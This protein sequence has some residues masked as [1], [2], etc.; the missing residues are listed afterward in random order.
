MRSKI[1]LLIILAALASMIGCGGTKFVE[2]GEEPTSGATFGPAALIRTADHLSA[3]LAKRFQH[4][5]ERVPIRVDIVKNKTSEHIDTKAVTDTI[6]TNLINSGNFKFSVDYT[7]LDQ[8]EK[9]VMKEIH[10]RI[11][12]MDRQMYLQNQVAPK[13]RVY[14]ELT[15]IKN[16]DSSAKDVFYKFTLKMVDFRT[17]T[18]TWADEKQ[19][20]KVTK[21]SW[22]GW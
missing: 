8:H 9:R 15:S 3:S 14:G 21:R 10:G 1:K 7:E 13:Y 2:P 5:P 16:I 12:E 19:L 17:G 4:T 20:R 11:S 6:I 18:L 22:F